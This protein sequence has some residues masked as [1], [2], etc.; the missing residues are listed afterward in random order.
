VVDDETQDGQEEDQEAPQD[1]FAGRS[2][3]VDHLH[4]CDDIEDED[5][6]ATNST[7][8][9]LKSLE[10]VRPAAANKEDSQGAEKKNRRSANAI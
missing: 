3:A 4:D 5:D 2:G 8:R 1:L 6:E 7:K 9:I 10:E